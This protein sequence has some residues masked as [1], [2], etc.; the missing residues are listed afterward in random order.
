MKYIVAL[1]AA[2]LV[3]GA[4]A[5]NAQGTGTGTGSSTSGASAM[6]CWDVSSNTV[7]NQAPG[8]SSGSASSSTVGLC[9]IG[10]RVSLPPR[11]YARLL[12]RSLSIRP[13]RPDGP[14][15]ISSRASRLRCIS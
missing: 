3:I 7:K 2:A 8:T 6:Q 4:V 14:F 13:A 1:S 5:A 10:Q 11:R 15:F 12:E 9:F